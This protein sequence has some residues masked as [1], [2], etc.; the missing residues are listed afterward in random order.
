MC[1]RSGMCVSWPAAGFW[2]DLSP[3]RRG[4]G[5]FGSP[6]VS[7]LAESPAKTGQGKD[8]LVTPPQTRWKFHP[9]A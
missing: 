1:P 6:A 7:F 8:R 5:L 9:K 4:G 2:V 3:K